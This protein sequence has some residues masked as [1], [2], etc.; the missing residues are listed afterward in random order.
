[1]AAAWLAPMQVVA[2]ADARLVTMI[3]TALSPAELQ[4]VLASHGVTGVRIQTDTGDDGPT[5]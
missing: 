1:M 3:E 2:T 4:A 5:H